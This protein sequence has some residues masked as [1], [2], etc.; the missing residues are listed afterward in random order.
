[1]SQ[2]H[3]NTLT[4]LSSQELDGFHLLIKHVSQMKTL[5]DGRDQFSDG[6]SVFIGNL[7]Y[8]MYE[9]SINIAKYLF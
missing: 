2:V 1:M 3:A 4:F 8:G 7:P 9:K 5:K 6:C